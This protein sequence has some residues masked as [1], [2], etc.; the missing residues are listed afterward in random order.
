MKFGKQ[1]NTD[2]GGSNLPEFLYWPLNDNKAQGKL[3]S[4]S[5]NWTSFADIKD[6]YQQKPKA[7]EKLKYYSDVF[8]SIELNTTF[9]RIPD[10]TQVINWSNDVH[11]G[12]RFCP[13][14]TQTISNNSNIIAQLDY[15]KEFQFA[16]S[17]FGNKLGPCFM[18]LPAHYGASKLNALL[19]FLDSVHD[20][21][22]LLIEL[23]H[24]SWFSDSDALNNLA[25]FLNIKQWGLVITDTPGRKDVLHGHICSNYSI[26]RFVAAEHKI[27][28]D[29]RIDEWFLRIQEMFKK[30]VGEVYFFIHC[31][32]PFQLKEWSDQM[33][34][35][36]VE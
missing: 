17:A 36:N 18:Q 2:S 28:D 20:P 21:I 26:I 34:K 16:I 23:R 33:M 25:S 5:T 10:Q 9:Y 35:L 1:Y 32:D 3:Y 4:G 29:N 13:K 31:N 24:D 30:G 8:N 19:A 11:D 6:F 12:F 14:L 7:K 27:T 22:K 15:F